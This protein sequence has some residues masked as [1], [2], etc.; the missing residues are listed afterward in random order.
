MLTWEFH[1]QPL[2][3]VVQ[4]YVRGPEGLGITSITCRVPLARSAS[5]LRMGLRANCGQRLGC[6]ER[7]GGVACARCFDASTTTTKK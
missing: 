3:G 2:R 5:G 7:M 6:I 4:G 1:T